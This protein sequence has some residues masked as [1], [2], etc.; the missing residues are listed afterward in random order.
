MSKATRRTTLLTLAMF[1]LSAHLLAQQAPPTGDTFVS[2]DTPGIN[3]GSSDIVA[4]G[5]GITTYLKFNLSGVPAGPTVS[6]ATLRLFVD[7]VAAGG[8]FDV[9]NLPSSPAWSEKTLKFNT[10]PPSLG[11]S[12]TGG[13]PITISAASLNTFLLIDITATVQEWLSN[14]STNNGVALAR[15]GST[16]FFSFDSKESLFTAHQPELEIALSGGSGPPGPQGVQGPQGLPGAVGPAG[17]AGTQGP[18]GDTG[19]PGGVGP[20]GPT[21]LSGPAGAT[22]A[23]GPQGPAGPQGPPGLAGG[24]N[25]IQEFTQNGAFAVPAGIT[26]ILVE[27]WGAGGGGSGSCG[28]PNGALLPGGGAGGGGGGYTRAV[29]PVTPGATYDVIIGSGGKGGASC[30]TRAC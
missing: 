14:P 25:G 27:L 9:Y 28:S 21:G 13:N 19:L 18:K 5:S 7:A 20:A 16:G 6:K 17:T 12:A 2:S 11:T 15:V 1:P 26:H 29:L 8:Q 3:Y 24:F 23:P 10:P 4:V 30:Q 22:G